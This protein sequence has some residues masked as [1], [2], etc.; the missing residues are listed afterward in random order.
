[1]QMLDEGRTS[2][3]GKKA[4]LSPPKRGMN[5]VWPHYITKKQKAPY[6][7]RSSGMRALLPTHTAPRMG[8]GVGELKGTDILY[9][10]TIEYMRWAIETEVRRTNH[11]PPSKIA[12]GRKWS[13]A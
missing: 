13:R 6:N 11:L 1:M 9:Y 10:M 4:A 8:S 5:T 7:L 12:S 2:H 3:K